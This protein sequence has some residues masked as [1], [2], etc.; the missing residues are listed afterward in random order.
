MSFH[1]TELVES[2]KKA[3]P[4]SIITTCE[5]EGLERGPVKLENKHQN[6]CS[7]LIPNKK[8][9]PSKVLKELKSALNFV[10]GDITEHENNNVLRLI[11]NYE[12]YAYVENIVQEIWLAFQKRIRYT[13]DMFKVEEFATIT[14]KKEYKL[15]LPFESERINLKHPSICNSHGLDLV[16]ESDM[17]HALPPDYLRHPLQKKMY[18]FRKSF[19][20]DVKI[21]QTVIHLP[22]K[23]R[24]VVVNK[25]QITMYN[26]TDLWELRPY[27]PVVLPVVYFLET[28]G[29]SKQKKFQAQIYKI[30]IEEHDPP[31]A[32]LTGGFGLNDT[33]WW[34]NQFSR[35][36]EY[37]RKQLNNNQDVIKDKTKFNL[38]VGFG[39]YEYLQ[40]H[41]LG[42]SSFV[43]EEPKQYLVC[44][45][46]SKNDPF[47]FG[48]YQP[49][50]YR[51]ITFEETLQ[52]NIFS[53]S[54]HNYNS[55]VAEPRTFE[56]DPSKNVLYTVDNLQNRSDP[57]GTF[58][59]AQN[60]INIQITRDT[61]FSRFL[62]VNP[63]TNNLHHCVS[64]PNNMDKSSI[65]TDT[66]IRDEIA[67]VGHQ[68]AKEVSC[69]SA[70][71]AKS[72]E[73]LNTIKKRNGQKGSCEFLETE[74]RCTTSLDVLL[75]NLETKRE[76]LN[77]VDEELESYYEIMKRLFASE[78]KYDRWPS[79]E[80]TYDAYT[81]EM[82]SRNMSVL[83][84]TELKQ[85]AWQ[86][87]FDFFTYLYDMVEREFLKRFNQISSQY[88]KTIE[89][90]N[91]TQTKTIEC[92]LDKFEDI[93]IHTEK[94]L[95]KSVETYLVGFRNRFKAIVESVGND[96]PY[97]F[98]QTQALVDVTRHN[99]LDAYEIIEKSGVHSWQAIINLVKQNLDDNYVVIGE[100]GHEEKYKDVVNKSSIRFVHSDIYEIDR[101]LNYMLLPTIMY[102]ILITELNKSPYIHSMLQAGG[103]VAEK[104]KKE[105]DDVTQSNRNILEKFL[106]PDKLG[107]K[108][109]EEGNKSRLQKIVTFF[110]PYLNSP[111]QELSLAERRNVNRLESDMHGFIQY[112]NKAVPIEAVKHDETKK[113][114][115]QKNV[116]QPNI[117]AQSIKKLFDTT[118][119]RYDKGQFVKAERVQLN[120]TIEA[121]SNSD[122]LTTKNELLKKIKE[123]LKYVVR[124]ALATGLQTKSN[125]IGLKNIWTNTNSGF[126]INSKEQDVVRILDR[127]YT[128]NP[129]LDLQTLF[130][131]LSKQIKYTI[132]P[133]LPY[134]ID[135]DLNTKNLQK[136]KQMIKEE[137]QSYVSVNLILDHTPKIITRRSKEILRLLVD[138]KEKNHIFQEP[139]DYILKSNE[140]KPIT[141]VGSFRWHS[142]C[143][144]VFNEPFSQSFANYLRQ[145]NKEHN[146]KF[147][148]LEQSLKKTL[149][150]DHLKTVINKE[151]C[152]LDKLKPDNIKKLYS[153]LN[154][155]DE[156]S[157]SKTIKNM[158]KLVPELR[159]L[160]SN[161][162]INKM[163]TNRKVLHFFKSYV[164]LELDG[165]NYHFV[166]KFYNHLSMYTNVNKDKY[167]FIIDKVYS[168]KD[169]PYP[170]VSYF[171]KE[172][173]VW[174]ANKKKENRRVEIIEDVFNNY[175]SEEYN[176]KD[177]ENKEHKLVIYDRRDG[178]VYY[179][180]QKIES[181]L[182]KNSV[183]TP[184][185]R[186]LTHILPMVLGANIRY[187]DRQFESM[188]MTYKKFGEK[189]NYMHKIYE[190]FQYI[191][192]FDEHYQKTHL[193]L[194]Q[195]LQTKLKD[196][197]NLKE[198]KEKA[199]LQAL[200]LDEDMTQQVRLI[201]KKLLLDDEALIDN[202]LSVL[203]PL[204]HTQVNSKLHLASIALLKFRYV[205][206]FYNNTEIHLSLKQIHNKTL[207]M[208]E[209]SP[210]YICSHDEMI[211]K[212]NKLNFFDFPINQ[213]KYNNFQNWFKNVEPTTKNYLFQYYNVHKEGGVNAELLDEHIK[214][215]VQSYI[216]TIQKKTFSYL[217][218]KEIETKLGYLL[219][220]THVLQEIKTFKTIKNNTKL[221]ILE[222][223]LI[224]ENPKDLRLNAG[225]KQTFHTSV[226]L[227]TTLC[228]NAMGSQVPI[229]LGGVENIVQPSTHS[230]DKQVSFMPTSVKRLAM[231]HPKQPNREPIQLIS[232][233]S[234]WIPGST[235]NDVTLLTD[236]PPLHPFLQI[237][238]AK[239]G[240]HGYIY[241]MVLTV[242][243]QKLPRVLPLAQHKAEK[244]NH[245]IIRLSPKTIMFT[246]AFLSVQNLRMV[247]DALVMSKA[248]KLPQNVQV[249]NSN[250]SFFRHIHILPSTVHTSLS[251][252]VGWDHPLIGGLI[253]GPARRS[254]NTLTSK[255]KL[256][257]NRYLSAWIS[258][259]KDSEIRVANLYQRYTTFHPEN[260]KKFQSLH[261]QL[262][263]IEDTWAMLFGGKNPLVA[264]HRLWAS[265]SFST[266]D[267]VLIEKKRA[268]ETFG[269]IVQTVVDKSGISLGTFAV[270]PKDDQKKLL[271]RMAKGI[272]DSLELELGSLEKET[273]QLLQAHDVYKLLLGRPEPPPSLDAIQSELQFENKNQLSDTQDVS[274]KKYLRFTSRPFHLEE[275][276]DNGCLAIRRLKVLK[277]WVS[278]PGSVH[279]IRVVPNDP[280]SVWIGKVNGEK[281]G[282]FRVMV[283]RSDMHKIV[284]VHGPNASMIH[285]PLQN[286]IE[287]EA[288][289]EPLV[290]VPG[291]H[292]RFSQE[293]GWMLRPGI[294]FVVSMLPWDT[295]TMVQDLEAPLP[296]TPAVP[297]VSITTGKGVWHQNYRWDKDE[298]PVKIKR[299]G[300]F[301]TD[302]N[303]A[304][305]I[306][307]S[308]PKHR[309]C[310]FSDINRLRWFQNKHVL[311]DQ[312]NCYDVLSAYTS[313][314]SDVRSMSTK[315]QAVYYLSVWGCVAPK[316]FSN[317]VLDFRVVSDPSRWIFGHALV[318]Y[319]KNK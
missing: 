179:G 113:T 137:N 302:K 247:F 35:L 83:A 128:I 318:P 116:T 60:M 16:V 303:I 3:V 272:Y 40:P 234:V 84:F 275:V 153:K 22:T 133:K 248:G 70:K 55:Y 205:E 250:Q 294:G 140:T 235:L 37:I 112:A 62:E 53:V 91:S 232:V 278:K 308:I 279:E 210:K 173:L 44:G 74:N 12:N 28:K 125:V 118:F 155:C 301:K 285:I 213:S 267:E 225:S 143:V 214:R 46:S 119:I 50:L 139:F 189:S 126:L 8:R 270:M 245:Q 172:Q 80:E 149:E 64:K 211:K 23:T 227:G 264:E 122:V 159:K 43:R 206:L 7:V 24:C 66:F 241:F 180:L 252:F 244:D 17:S 271:R 193:K 258:A 207:R 131:I 296:D 249:D 65:S 105:V 76:K 310:L 198:W 19:C 27:T 135:N 71:D 315:R 4:L 100:T 161:T 231:N 243:D 107:T 226:D 199:T 106:Y 39:A 2:K 309:G 311:P 289:L 208:C 110:V 77:K 181:I 259:P 269:S 217:P 170:Y 291:I 184:I 288:Q 178:D 63:D 38:E 233:P 286:I 246:H 222:H 144:D 67:R 242:S 192:Q 130:N 1:N 319:S 21:G 14:S 109:D 212:V 99:G 195:N 312:L 253:Q 186:I 59:P 121:L 138:G 136:I 187:K 145:K 15:L 266:L 88:R 254:L 204:F 209:I 229:L 169:E 218:L 298:R 114:K 90:Q 5:T 281:E 307:S 174:V 25:H 268:Q 216:Q 262:V 108:K 284:F 201:Y 98:E 183:E 230:Q 292:I 52:D 293:S 11:I 165:H 203:L 255:R 33:E 163:Y 282:P 141:Y 101:Y 31:Q 26:K 152:N 86:T 56:L 188:K 280:N 314:H 317:Y 316:K 160:I 120:K 45:N 79:I 61:P 162:K 102:K 167:V 191:D 129:T 97:F 224:V 158:E 117:V 115:K 223:N 147:G 182:I 287:F 274:S 29:E 238:R 157:L 305:T 94:Q 81:S 200:N 261:N 87:Y 72:C 103:G 220:I 20:P 51:N 47:L 290:A 190:S 134:K 82:K 30:K 265:K 6:R 48:K 42:V 18:V 166:M 123:L 256:W 168:E 85:K 132:E 237:Y 276:L 156:Y 13:Y 297:T 239:K 124:L 69:S 251:P 151:M 32:A 196:I 221:A 34:K 194:W 219:L 73:F 36:S 273:K 104:S 111:K 57:Y 313:N 58:R 177:N 127:T 299:L 148:A 150:A 260:N 10:F 306:G 92:Y 93:N 197:N 154:L 89:S 175:F 295:R 95:R 185:Q 49:D 176:L 146:E 41:L 54:F 257:L 75:Q 263:D 228:W 215:N 171:E 68:K 202:Q 240:L 9:F 300:P 277:Y 142:R 78:K 283:V 96:N 304:A 236:A 164:A